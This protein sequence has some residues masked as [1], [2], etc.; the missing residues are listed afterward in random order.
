[1]KLSALAVAVVI[2]AFGILAGAVLA[3]G[4]FDAEAAKPPPPD[5][6][7]SP[8]EFTYVMADG[9]Q[10]STELCLRGTGGTPNVNPELESLSAQGWTVI[11]II[12]TQWNSGTV[13][14][15]TLTRPIP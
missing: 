7:P 13:L 15:Y 10:S 3:G 9:C 14:M 4:V 12:F 1:M 6:G 5:S 2:L 8:L 11:D